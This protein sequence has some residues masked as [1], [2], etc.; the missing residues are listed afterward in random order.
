[1]AITAGTQFIM[2]SINLAGKGTFTGSIVLPRIAAAVG[3]SIPAWIPVIAN[4]RVQ[5]TTVGVLGAGAV[6]GKL[7]FAGQGAGVMIAALNSAGLTGVN[8][9]HLGTAVGNGVWTALNALA[10]YV[11]VSPGVGLGTDVSTVLNANE[12]ALLPILQAN[13]AGQAI[14]GINSAQLAQGLSR[15][16]ATIVKTGFGVGAVVGSPSPIPAVSTSISTV[17]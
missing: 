11:G 13:L 9:T 4:V 6:T 8:A 15:G 3:I 17:F 14:V 7:M 2:D 1:M 16:I 12:A 10:Q 5:G